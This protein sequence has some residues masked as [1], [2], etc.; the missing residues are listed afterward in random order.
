MQPRVMIRHK[1]T[2]LIK[3][4][5]LLGLEITDSGLKAQTGI[6]MTEIRFRFPKANKV[7]GGATLYHTGTLHITGEGY[8]EF[9][10][11]VQAI[12]GVTLVSTNA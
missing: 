5:E 8:S 3:A 6:H 12:D 1:L 10:E 4:T 9:A 2:G 7:P 11:A